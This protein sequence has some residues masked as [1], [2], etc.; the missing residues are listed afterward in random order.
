MSTYYVPGNAPH[1]VDAAAN[2]AVSWSFHPKENSD[3]HS[4]KIDGCLYFRNRFEKSHLKHE[5]R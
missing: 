3:Q 5:N 2:K 4:H 1:I